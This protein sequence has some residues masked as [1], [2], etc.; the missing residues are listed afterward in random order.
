MAGE[1]EILVYDN[2][3]DTTASG[4]YDEGSDQTTNSE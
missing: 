3:D 2:S 1:N 4:F